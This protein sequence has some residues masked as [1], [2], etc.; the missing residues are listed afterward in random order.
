[1]KRLFRGYQHFLP[2]T[3]T[4]EFY[5]FFENFDLGNF[6]STVSARVFIFHMNIPCNKMFLL[7]LKLL[8][9]TFDIFLINIIHNKMII[10]RVSI[11]HMSNSCDKIFLLVSR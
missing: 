4:L 8:I 10:N 6:F 7:V 5:L 1:M 3:L 9:L 11:L 2:G